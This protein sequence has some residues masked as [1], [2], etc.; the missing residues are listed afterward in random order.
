[1]KRPTTIR[2]RS[3]AIPVERKPLRPTK[4]QTVRKIAA[5]RAGQ[6]HIEVPPLQTA[7]PD[8]PILA[9][10]ER[11]LAHRPLQFPAKLWGEVI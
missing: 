1:M 7:L 9:E 10:V 4:W 8:R 3:R 5:W 6:T 11:C 2:I